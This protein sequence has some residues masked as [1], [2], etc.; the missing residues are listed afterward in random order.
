MLGPKMLSGILIVLPATVLLTV[1][2]GFGGSTSDECR[3]GPGAS[4]R[5]GLHWYYRVE[6]VRYHVAVCASA[7]QIEESQRII[8]AIVGIPNGLTQ[9]P[10]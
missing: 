3:P 10:I 9:P 1:Q 2:S 4:A 6:L 8:A 7:L 5:A